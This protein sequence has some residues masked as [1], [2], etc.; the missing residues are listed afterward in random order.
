MSYLSFYVLKIILENL[1]IR[2]RHGLQSRKYKG[3]KN[4]RFWGKVSGVV[5]EDKMRIIKW[6]QKNDAKA[7]KWLFD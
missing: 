1:V 5:G 3:K 6:P 2:D 4:G 7:L